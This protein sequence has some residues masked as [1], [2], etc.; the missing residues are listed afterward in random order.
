MAAQSCGEAKDVLLFFFLKIL[1][2]LF[3]TER[4]Q[5]GGAAEVEGSR[6]SDEQ[7]LILSIPM[8]MT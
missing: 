6:R 4:A 1:F 2:Y 3:D 5:A 8:I 7:G